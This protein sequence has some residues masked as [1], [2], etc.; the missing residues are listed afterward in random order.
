MKINC[1]TIFSHRDRLERKRF[2]DCLQ[3]IQQDDPDCLPKNYN[4]R[5][6]DTS[7]HILTLLNDRDGRYYQKNAGFIVIYCDKQL[8][9]CAGYHPFSLDKKTGSMVL[10][11]F[12]IN[13]R[14]R[15]GKIN[16]TDDYWMP[17]LIENR[18]KLGNFLWMSFNEDRDSLY[19]AF[20]RQQNG[21]SVAFAEKWPAF[22]KNFY[23]IGKRSIY[24]TAQSVVESVNFLAQ[25]LD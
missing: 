8:I 14:F 4:L 1:E 23:P 13:P 10:S 2:L 19:K 21:Q 16:V 18:P 7:G 11:R 25:R 24:S 5:D 9:A 3:K 15:A 22:Y 20:V 12:F 6:I 17:A